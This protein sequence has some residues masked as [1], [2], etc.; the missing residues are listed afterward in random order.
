LPQRYRILENGLIPHFVT[1][2]IVDWLP[3]FISE[4]YCQV[5]VESLSY[6]RQEKGLLV[7]AYVIMPTHVHSILSVVDGG[8]L[9]DVIRDAR[10]FTAKRI[11]QLLLQDGNKLYDWLFRNA[12]KRDGRPEGSY[13][14]WAEG[15]H[16]ETLE[17]A[18]FALQKLNYLHDNPVRKGF[19]NEP[20]HWRYSSAENYAK[21][22]IGPLEIDAL[23]F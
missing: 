16:P 20:E 6:C 5:I 19:V 22:L 17:T 2:T 12:A 4:R 21:G 11:V 13:M 8:D 10:K 7:H 1:W 9:S 18:E 14:V 23:E 15:V 3:V